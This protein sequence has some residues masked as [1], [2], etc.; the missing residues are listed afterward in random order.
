MDSHVDVGPD[1][2]AAAYVPEGEAPTRRVGDLTA[3]DVDSVIRFDGRTV[4]LLEPP[5]RKDGL[6]GLLVHVE[7]TAYDL[8]LT[9]SPDQPYTLVSA[10]ARPADMVDAT[11]AVEHARELDR[12]SARIVSLEA[13]L[14]VLRRRKRELSEALLGHFA[15]IGEKN[16][17]FDDRIAFVFPELYPEFE[18]RED[19]T[20][21]T[22]R[23]L[24]PVLEEL[25]R[26]GAIKPAEAGYK[27]LLAIFREYAK[28]GE[29][30]PPKL[31]AMVRPQTAQTVRVGPGKA[32]G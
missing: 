17:R 25:G 1:V 9:C 10:P 24:V 22:L 19:G 8:P 31:A 11:H 28:A 6:V 18:Q 30:L 7:G 21:Y 4:T 3:D 23:D 29:P 20:R 15:A 32:S 2:L 13:E 5:Y 16:L 27:A 14:P 12:V 26:H